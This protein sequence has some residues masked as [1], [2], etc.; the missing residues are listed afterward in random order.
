MGILRIL[1]SYVLLSAHF[2]TL[3]CHYILSAVCLKLRA[4]LLSYKL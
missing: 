3:L 2:S 1:N 4:A